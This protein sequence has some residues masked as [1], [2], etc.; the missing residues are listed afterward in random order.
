MILEEAPEPVPVGARDETGKG[1]GASSRQGLAGAIPLALSAKA[2]PALADAAKRLAAHLQENPELDPTD[3]AYSLLTTRSAFEHRAVALGADRE[4]L[5]AS[6]KALANGDPSPNVHSARAKDGKLA[7]LFTG[8]GSQRLGMGKELYESDPHFRDAFDAVCAE[9]DPHLETPLKEI[10][11]A[12]GKKAAALLD[13]TTYAQPALFAIE[14]ALYK[15]LSERGL[16]PD[17]LTGHSIG[18]IAAAHL[19]GVFEL[20]DAAKLVAARGAL[21]GA[22]PPG[23]AMAAIEA[24]EQEVAESIEGKEGELSIAAVNGPTST[25]ISGSEEVVEAI[26]TEWETQ[27]RKTK[28]LVVS[29]AFHSPLIEPMLEEFAEVANSLS[30]SEPKLPI[31]SNLSGELLSAEQATD[32][33]YWVAHVRE[34]VRF[35]DAV[36]T[37]AKQGATTYMELGPDP[38]LCAMARECLADEDEQAAFVP[39]LREG[40]AEADTLTTAIAHA[41]AAGAKLDWGAFFAGTGARRVPL[42]TYPFQRRRYWLSPSA[43]AG[44]PNAIGQ[45]PVEHPLLVAAVED[46][47]EGGLTLTGRISAQAQPWLAGHLLG[48]AVLLPGPVFL[49]LALTAAEQTGAELVEELTVQSPLV[50]LEDG[51]VAIQV[52]VSAPGEDGGREIAIHSRPD[53]EEGGWSENAIGVLSAQRVAGEGRFDSGSAEGA[54]GAETSLP[55]EI[56]EEAGRYAIHPELLDAALRDNGLARSDAE[57]IEY[58]VSWSRVALYAVGARALRMRISPGEGEGVSFLL[59]DSAGAPVASVGELISR[60]LDRAQL[61]GIEQLHEGLLELDWVEVPLAAQDAVP[62]KIELL[63]CEVEGEAGS[64]ATARR[65]TQS[66]L[67]A[68]QVWL[69]DESNTD[70]RLALITRGAMAPEDGAAPDPAAAAV[71]G[72]IRSAQSEHPGRFALIDSDGSEASEAALPAA[73]AIGAEEPQLA[74][75]EGE[76]L[77]PRLVRT[78]ESTWTGMPQRRSTPSAPS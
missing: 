26:R 43:G 49:E 78:A 4:E 6:L 77:A 41:H 34:P 57:R 45:R 48:G 20:P 37:L 16:K 73:L 29:H 65:A 70:S 46:P 35:A 14:V 51:G 47:S 74:L 61:K 68:I 36:E 55:E 38:V 42:P 52:R 21:M 22:L 59:A 44:G 13:D 15:A 2:E 1:S 27:G 60:P 53:G 19:S 8:Q 67:A 5:L 12:K 24:T 33:A 28:R 18:E 75:R 11:F 56:A 72:L 63:H 54:E 40:R 62:A 31:V 71:W 23:G 39:T 10:V 7:Y 50:L 9:L 32:P 64:A 66:A 3:V 25:V 58:P 69:G 17:I 30:F 76:A